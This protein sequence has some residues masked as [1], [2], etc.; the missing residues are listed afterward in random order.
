MS[1]VYCLYS[2]QDGIPQYIGKTEADPE[3]RLKEHLARA[4]EEDNRSP[5]YN[6]NA[7]SSGPAT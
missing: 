4:L 2:T 3:R 5:L 6:W 1:S 7:M